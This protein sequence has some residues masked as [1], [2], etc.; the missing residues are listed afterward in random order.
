VSHSRCPETMTSP[1]QHPLFLLWVG[2][3]QAANFAFFLALTRCAR[4]WV[5][6]ISAYI[7]YVV[8]LIAVFPSHPLAHGGADG[9]SG[10][11]S[12]SFICFFSLWALLATS[13]S[14]GVPGRRLFGS[15]LCG[16]HQL[17][18]FAVSLLFMRNFASV[19]PLLATALMIL[20]A[21]FLIRWILPRVERMPDAS[22]W[23]Y[24]N[25]MAVSLFVL[26]YGT[27]LRPVYVA[28]ADPAN[29]FLFGAAAIVAVAFF[30]TAIAFSEKSSMA[31]ALASV[32]SSLRTM[33]GEMTERR[34]VIA[35]ARQI[36]N[37]RLMHRE[38]LI[39]LLKQN[40]VEEALDY[41]AKLQETIEVP[42]LAESVWCE[43]ETVNAIL[44]GYSR[45]AS[46]A[47]LRFSAMASID[48]HCVL[49]EVEL[50][51]LLSNL[52]EI[53]LGVASPEGEVTCLLRQ[54]DGSFGVTVSTT[55]A[56]EFKLSDDGYPVTRPNA[57]LE[58]VLALS[59]KH[60]GECRYRQ[61]DGILTGNA[62]FPL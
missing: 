3:T 32:E 10:S 8:M 47:G 60:K 44:A 29:V 12:V 19:G 22:G 7:V 49:P 26:L 57:S 41:L 23:L 2:A 36:R 27:C 21:W 5:R 18:A 59:R 13:M 35:R 62:L 30:P 61:A 25:L 11:L 4:G 54:R 40:R 50:V 16:I 42:L 56:P 6:T 58:S 20:M 9:T 24:L 17:I 45:K 39:G 52:L 28:S 14:R 37:D 33:A 46:A 55:V 48:T 38:T 51:E 31:F 15:V 43:N 34:E 53:G 1:E